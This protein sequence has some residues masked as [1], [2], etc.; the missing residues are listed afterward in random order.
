M[1]IPPRLSY[2]MLGELLKQIREWESREN[3]GKDQTDKGETGK[4]VKLR[5]L[6]SEHALK[7]LL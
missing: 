3:W 6:I 7:E 4:K 5:I 2:C 1:A